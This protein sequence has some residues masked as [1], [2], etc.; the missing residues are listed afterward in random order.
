MH[1]IIFLLLSHSLILF[2][3][4]QNQL[5]NPQ[6]RKNNDKQLAFQTG[7]KL[8]YSLKFGFVEGGTAEITLDEKAY[9]GK[10]VYYTQL[11]AQTTGILDYIFDVTDV[12]S[13]YF[14]QNTYL[15]YK[16]IRN[17]HE[18]E[19]R[20]FDEATYYHN[21]KYL[22]S[23][24]KGKLEIP[25]NLMDMVSIVY[26]LRTIDYNN[27]KTGDIIKIKIYFDDEVTPFDMR[28]MGKEII[29]TDFGKINCI[30]LMPFVEPG[31]V[32]KTADDLIIWIS[33]D[34]N[35]VP[36]RVK[37]NLKV[38]SIRADLKSYSKLKYPLAVN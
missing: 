13:C 33:N 18:N 10:K 23:K 9:N 25:D 31:R 3:D 29:N 12:Y 21:E 19:Y 5:N 30:K 6:I 1:K 24:R 16:S 36:I 4:Q 28:Y 32:Y 34:N 17:I 11:T 8:L 14:D 26:Y 7:E 22:I 15:P 35:L 37:F 27:L 2:S 20:L 38:G